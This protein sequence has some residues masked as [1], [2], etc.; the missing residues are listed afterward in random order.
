[1]NAISLALVCLLVLVP[2]LGASLLLFGRRD[3][4]LP[5]R[6]ATMFVLGV[7]V[8]G[9]VAYTLAIA[10]V[11]RPGA[12]FGAVGGVTAV[13]WFGGLRRASARDLLRRL[14]AELRADP[15]TLGVG[16]AMVTAIA[17]VRTTVSPL[18]NFGTPTSWRYWADGVEI[19]DAG[20]LPSSVLQYGRML[21]PS[22]NKVV[23]N[24]LTAGVTFMIGKEPLPGMAAMLWVGSVGLA[25]A[26][27]SLGRE[28]GLRL[29]AP[30]VPVLVMANLVFLD[31][32]V[33]G[34]LSTFK[35]ETFGRL[36]AFGGLALAIRAIR[37][38]TGWAEAIAAAVALAVAAG[39]HLVP[40]VVSVVMLVLY[41][42]AR[43]VIDRDLLSIELRAGLVLGLGAATAL[44]ILVLPHG[45]AGIRA[46]VG[47]DVYSSF[48]PRFDPTLYLNGGVLPGTTE[49]GP[50]TWD[51][52]IGRSLDL[53]TS[54]ATGIARTASSKGA[55][56]WIKF[57][58]V[59]GGALLVVA[60]LLWFPSELKP[61]A[62]VGWGLGLSL[63]VLTWLFSI[64]YQLYIPSYFGVRRLL[65]YS[66]IPIILL[67][68]APAEA[69]LLLLRSA[70][71]H[72]P[73]V[74]AAIVV[75]AVTA[76]VLPSAL[77]RDGGR[78]ADRGLVQPFEWI[79]RNVPCEARILSNQH[80]EGVF[81]ALTGRVAILEGMTP[82]LRFDILRPIVSLLLEAK[83][84]FEHPAETEAFLSKEGV[85]YIILLPVGDVG[86]RA[87][88]GE[89][90]RPILDAAPFLRR[91]YASPGAVVY[92]VV[93]SVVGGS[94]F[95]SPA[96]AAGYP[97]LRD[98][99]PR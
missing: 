98:P 72:L 26:L 74:V 88:V 33:T 42:V 51:V 8:D 83:D 36:V 5:T 6:L 35:A 28:L 59:V 1:M 41:A 37:H 91:V 61:V 70:R 58:L 64:R 95:P 11:L 18:R 20:R 43:A 63:V 84:F 78:P 17:V 3:V 97:C 75:V 85:D 76:A 16:L 32:E 65:D 22:T 49:V 56:T 87:P 90:S 54:A 94:G 79:R 24:A 48:A 55:L 12:F 47:T 34:D 67:M 62:L 30:L 44:V 89:A 77:P 82:Y 53:F 99:M 27:W 69:A 9:L 80:T 81:E 50:R 86:Y 60:G 46:D 52:P 23:L 39:I 29:L 4:G 14:A 31:K 73:Q 15:W 45:N 2:G 19:A 10:G 57:V 93:G 96:A 7:V 13:L 71:A 21:V 92:R 25:A 38:R 66:S 68:L 40:V